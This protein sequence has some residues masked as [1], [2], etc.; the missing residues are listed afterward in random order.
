MTNALWW[1]NALA[2]VTPPPEAG[3]RMRDLSRRSLKALTNHAAITN[4][5]LSMD[6]AVVLRW[7]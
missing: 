6:Y 4:R 3:L 7:I 1:R 2:T 5:G